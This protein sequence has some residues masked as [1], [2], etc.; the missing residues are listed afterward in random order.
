M[1]PGTTYLPAASTTAAVSTVSNCPCR[2]MATIFS[3]LTAMSSGW[4][5]C[6][7][8]TLPFLTIRSYMASFPFCGLVAGLELRGRSDGPGLAER[9]VLLR[10]EPEMPEVE[11]IVVPAEGAAEG[12]HTTGRSAK[13]RVDVG[14]QRRAELGVVHAE[15]ELA[16]AEVRVRRDLA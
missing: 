7:S 1:P 16:G 14:G 12:N 3:S 15:Q 9:V 6:S 4:T 5:E 13:P 2:P 8:T 10:S 11:L